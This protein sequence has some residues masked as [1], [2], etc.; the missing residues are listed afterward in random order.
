M[1]LGQFDLIYQSI[2]CHINCF[3]QWV[4]GGAMRRPGVIWGVRIGSGAVYALGSI[5]I[6]SYFNF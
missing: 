6:L 3:A 5:N 2:I 1:V 4:W